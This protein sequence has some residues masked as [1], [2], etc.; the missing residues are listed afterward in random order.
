MF[1]AI[2]AA[3]TA[4]D[5]ARTH[6]EHALRVADYDPGELERIEERLFALRGFGAGSLSITVQFFAAF[7]F[8][9]AMLLLLACR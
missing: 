2:D 8:F 4:L 3:L 7:G 1:T 5:D 6:L 9:F